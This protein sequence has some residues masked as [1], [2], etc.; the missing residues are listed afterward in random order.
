MLKKLF[1]LSNS[2]FVNAYKLMGF[3]VLTAVLLGIISYLSMSIF[4]LIDREWVAPIILSP[5]SERVIQ[6]NSQL[7]QQQYNYDK[8]EVERLMLQAQLINIER[9]IAVNGEFQERF[10]LA[11]SADLKVKQKERSSLAS[12]FRDYLATKKQVGDANKEFEKLGQKDMKKDLEAGLIEEEGYIRTKLALSQSITNQIAYNQKQLE[13]ESRSIEMNRKISALKELEAK[14]SETDTE[15]GKSP[16]Y[17]V[18]LME[19]EY[20]SS[21]LEMEQLDAQK[22]PI[23]RQIV[24]LDKSMSEY[25]KILTTIKESPYYKAMSEKISIAFVPYSNLPNVKPGASVYGC[26][27][28]LLWC[29]EVGKVVQVLDGEVSARHPMFSSDLRG[30]M[31]EIKLKDMTWA[32]EKALHID[33]RPFFI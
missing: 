9:T 2:M 7:V 18:L 20:Q 15:D 33:S 3:V 4:Y 17:D 13:F 25:G 19:K 26:S 10:K 23:E 21:L 22:K 27:L 1:S 32:E 5:S 6:V 11:V 14:L 8:L 30:V 29:K 24:L 16:N 28:E 12:L 31:V